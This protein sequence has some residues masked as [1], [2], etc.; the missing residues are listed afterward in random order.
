MSL[1]NA[2]AS[3]DLDEILAD[4]ETGGESC[5]IIS[6]GGSSETFSVLSCDIHLAIDP[7]TGEFVTGRQVT[8]GLS[9]RDLLSAGFS[10]IRGIASATSKPWTVSLVDVLGRAH[11]LK[12]IA[13]HPDN[14]LG[15]TQLVLGVYEQ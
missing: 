11:T 10:D 3:A 9:A 7:G 4:S 15:L 1:L 8:I 2:I 13:S 5:V 12:V 14:S 6:P